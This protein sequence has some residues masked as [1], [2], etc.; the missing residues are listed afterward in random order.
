MTRCIHKDGLDINNPVTLYLT[1]V[2]RSS[3]DYSWSYFPNTLFL[4][5]GKT[6]IKIKLKYTAIDDSKAKIAG[7]AS[8]GFNNGKSPISSTGVKDSAFI[9]ILPN[10]IIDFGVYIAIT[11]GMNPTTIF[12]DPQAS[13]DPKVESF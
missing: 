9:T 1:I 4:G 3:G 12:C 13:N 8:T 10:Q 11:G 6:D 5:E 2:Q 7:Y